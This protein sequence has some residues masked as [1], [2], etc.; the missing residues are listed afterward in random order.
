MRSNDPI[1]HKDLE[2]PSKK[3]FFPWQY[4]IVASFMTELA[5]KDRPVGLEGLIDLPV[6]AKSTGKGD[7]KP[8]ETCREWLTYIRNCDIYYEKPWK[9]VYE[10]IEGILGMSLK[11]KRE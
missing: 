5:E 8:D 1:W 4:D 10:A 3:H 7:L 6:P 2:R 9:N 11:R